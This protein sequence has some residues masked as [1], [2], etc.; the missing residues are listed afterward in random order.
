[1]RYQFYQI[2]H[3]VGVFMVFL[4][5]GGMIV[6]SATG[7]DNKGIRR[8]GSMT[9]GIGL[10]LILVGGFGLLAK[11]NY[12]WPVWVLIKMGIWVLLGGMIAIINRKPE[13]SQYSWWGTILL[14]V[15]AL[16]MVVLKPFTG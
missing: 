3:L 6:R 11:L 12:G 8:L 15:I 1:M 2:I 14:G 7:S 9:S 4:S 13:Y 16:L 5:Y 10:L